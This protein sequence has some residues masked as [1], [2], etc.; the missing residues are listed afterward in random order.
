MALGL[1]KPG[2]GYWMRVVTATMVGTLFLAMAMWIAG[3]AKAFVATLPSSTYSVTLESGAT[4]AA[5]TQGSRVTLLGRPTASNLEPP[6]IGS[7]IVESYDAD[8]R[9]L[10]LGSPSITNTS[11]SIGDARDFRVDGDSGQPPKYAASSAEAPRGQAIVEPVLVQGIAAAVILIIGAIITYWLCAIRPKT[12]DFLINTDMEM[13]K[14]NW[15][16]RKDIIGSTWVVIGSSFLIAAFIFIA[17]FLMQAF[18]KSI[19]VL[20]T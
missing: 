6:V 9:R 2:Q 1:Y 7:A 17:D 13:K 4:G 20:H 15:S 12:V 5:P 8:N 18:F 14:V 3:Q 11:F 19:G 10:V 16:T